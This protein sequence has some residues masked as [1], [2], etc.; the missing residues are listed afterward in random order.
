[1]REDSKLE[2]DGSIYEV[3]EELV[4]KTQLEIKNYLTACQD[5]MIDKLG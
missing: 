5:K 3:V 2:I 1:M 4:G